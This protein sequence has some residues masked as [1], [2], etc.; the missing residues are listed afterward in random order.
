MTGLEKRWYRGPGVR[1]VRWRD[2]LSLPAS[3]PTTSATMNAILL[4]S[5][6]LVCAADEPPPAPKL[7]LGKETTF[8]TG[9]L[10]KHGYIDYEAALNA[11]LGKGIAPEKNASAL[12]VLALGPTPM[13]EELPPEYYKWLNVSAPPRDGEYFITFF[14]FNQ[15]S[16]RLAP[17]QRVALT[18]FRLRAIQRAWVPKDC[19]PLAE[20]LAANEKPLALVRE[21][22]ARPHYF[23]PLI[24]PRK[25]GAPGF[26]IS[27]GSFSLETYRDLG[28]ALALRAT[29]RLG[30]KKYDEA[31]QDII[32][33]HRLGRLL[34][35][36]AHFIESFVG[37]AIC[38]T[39]GSATLAYLDRADLSSKR[40]LERLKELHALPP[41]MS[42]AE[43]TWLWKR[44]VGLDLLQGL[45]RNRAT[46]LTFVFNDGN[47]PS[48]EDVKA[49]DKL[50][51]GAVMQ[52]TNK[53]FGRQV[54]ALRLE[55]RSARE[56]ELSQ[57]E[58]EFR[59]ARQELGTRD[60]FLKLLATKDGPPL[61]AKKLSNFLAWHAFPAV[62]RV[63]ESHDRAVQGARNLSVAFALAAFDKDNDG[64]PTQLANLAPKYLATVPNDLFSGKSLSYKPTEKG[65]LFYSVGVNGLD[66][67]GRSDTDD[68]PG[69]DISVTMPLRELK[70]K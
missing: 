9:P 8:V 62:R 63:R 50:D 5:L 25:D 16:L 61:A 68:P 30:E 55:D 48:R 54:A 29:L 22:V 3:H 53:S 6:L 28:T 19:P 7:P 36:G 23:N 69:D 64:Y 39:A 70:K 20:W 18:E 32:A 57:I 60:E 46:A 24:S 37:T 15:S 38:Q 17:A 4:P 51:W 12:L 34:T 1:Y 49:L 27:A 58:N 26:L 67:G 40:T 56:K 52:R 42:L 59:M 43:N 21:A 65:Y 31:W 41:M 13:G 33:C 11:E 2:P 47:N 45:Q 44:L 10:D 35:R 14:D 66:E